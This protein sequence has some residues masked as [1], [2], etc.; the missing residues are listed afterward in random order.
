MSVQLSELIERIKKEGVQS[1]EQ[2]AARIKEQA[3]QEAAGLLASARRE[4]ED[5]VARARTEATRFEETGKEGVRQAARDV[6]LDL[7]KQLT[8]MLERILNRKITD[9]LGGNAIRD[10]LAALFAN[11]KNDESLDYEVLVPAETW[12]RIKESLLD[13][14]AAELKRGVEIKPS[15]SVRAGFKISEKDGSAYFD[16]TDRGLTEFLMEYLNPRLAE[17]LGESGS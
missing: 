15:G 2:D 7:K 12:D 17:S 13:G 16:F 14:L 11:W 10:G 5:I 8:G 3:E 9:D 4:A 6:V 1:A